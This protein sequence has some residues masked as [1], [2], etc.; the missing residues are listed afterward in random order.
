MKYLV[1][2]NSDIATCATND[3]ILSDE[4]I[5]KFDSMSGIIE[6]ITEIKN[7][8]AS[9]VEGSTKDGYLKGYDEGL[10]K[11]QQDLN[12]QFLE[13]LK[14]LTDNIIVNTTDSDA[15]IINMACEVTRIIVEDL[16]SKDVLTNLAITAIKKLKQHKEIEIKV[17]PEYRKVLQEKLERMNIKDNYN[18]STLEIVSDPSMGHLDCTIKSDSGVTVASFDDQLMLLKKNIESKLLNT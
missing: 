17:R 18:Y 11:G 3:Y 12:T 10:R 6:M 16:D 1:I 8:E 7:S 13:Y 5:I 14:D 4:D 15:E 2:L 9:K